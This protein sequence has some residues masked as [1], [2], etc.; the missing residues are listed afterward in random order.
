MRHFMLIPMVVSVLGNRFSSFPPDTLAVRAPAVPLILT[1]QF[2]SIWSM[3]DKLT[4]DYTKHWTIVFDGNGYKAMS[5]LIRV[6]GVVYRL[7]GPACPANQPAMSQQGYAR[8]YPTSTLATFQ[9]AGVQ[10]NMTFTYP[11]NP[12][13]LD[14]FLP[15]T[16]VTWDVASTDGQGHAVQLYWDITGQMSVNTDDQEVVW[17]RVDVPGGSVQAIRLGTASQSLFDGYGDDFRIDWGWLHLATSNTTAA[18]LAAVSSNV[19]RYWF[20]AN[21]TVPPVD[22]TVMPVAACQNPDPSLPHVCACHTPGYT[23][24]ANDWPALTAAIDMGAVQPGAATPS[25]A[26]VVVSYDDVQSIR[27]MGHAQPRYW[28]RPAREGGRNMPQVLAQQVSQHEQLVTAALARD[29]ELVRQWREDSGLGEPFERLASLSYRQSFADNMLTWYN[30][31]FTGQTTP[32][33]P[34]LWVKGQASSGDTGTLDDNY[35]A[36]PLFLLTQP[37]LV[38]YFLTPLL[39]WAGNE[40]YEG[41]TATFPL[42]MTYSLPWA[43][44]YLGQ[45]PVPELQC[46]YPPGFVQYCEP[47][48][49][50]MS[51]DM[52]TLVAATAAQ[53][54]DYSF[55]NRYYGLL[56][57]YA[58]YLVANG[59]YPGSQR[60]SDDYEG[61][62]TNSTHLSLKSILALAAWAQVCNATG[63]AAQGVQYTATAVQYRDVWLA[64]AWDP[65]GNYSMM[66]FASPGTWSLKYSL[67]L[68]AGLGLGLI[69]QEL[70]DRECRWHASQ[71]PAYGWILQQWSPPK[72]S[73]TNLGWEGWM[74]GVCPLDVASGLV[75]KM[76]DYVNNT[77]RRLPLSD[78]YDASTAA[79]QGFVGR[80]QVGGVFAL[81]WLQQ[82]RRRRRLSRAQ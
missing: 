27:Y 20:S 36:V 50:E 44:H 28:A 79:Y 76:L 24:A 65:S 49:I 41:P 82:L 35:P 52:L 68:D 16:H 42:N 81:P 23:G 26:F 51:A 73:W 25:T 57:S 70:V 38:E 17:D 59:L 6:D 67:L 54:G 14:T 13:E 45:H 47:M 66:Q 33:G 37:R 72:N 11:L 9:G 5:S 53:T 1:D 63:R 39:M 40:T 34:H 55:A 48:P 29:A 4:D 7:L 31:S 30:G 3:N 32:P 12:S 43:P 15:V 58:Q 19:A 10:V 75:G 46:W 78:W 62:L 74:A 18:A 71:A 61:F 56:D 80:A 21:G 64:S 77:D 69:P 60:S 22:E 2:F 8:V